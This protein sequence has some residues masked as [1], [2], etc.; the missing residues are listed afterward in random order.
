MASL[1]RVRSWWRGETVQP[2]RPL[3]EWLGRGPVLP[4]L[5]ALPVCIVWGAGS[6]LGLP[7]L[8]LNDVPPMQ[9]ASFVQSPSSRLKTPKSTTT[10]WMD[11][12]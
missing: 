5:Q 9:R 12:S 8:F 11:T 10:G 1:E 6:E 7:S 2:L 4:V 3:L